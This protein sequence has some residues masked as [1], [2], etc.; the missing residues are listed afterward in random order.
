MRSKDQG[1]AKW[2]FECACV[3]LLLAM[4]TMGHASIIYDESISGDLPDNL[5][6]VLDLSLGTNT[7]LG[8]S[9]Y[10]AFDDSQTYDLDSFSFHLPNDTQ[11]T[12]VSYAFSNTI[13]EPTT[14]DL[15]TQYWLLDASSNVLDITVIA[16]SGTSPVSLFNSALPLASGQY[17]FY[18]F[19][20]GTVGT[21]TTIG[22]SWDY[23]ITFDVAATPLPATLPLFATGLGALGLLG[24]RRKRKN[25]PLAAA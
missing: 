21:A 23:Q 15:G 16:V 17:Q 14:S 2:F 8:S 13:L 5:T 10:I 24:W 25:A 20:L 19:S 6:T 11:L 7:V 22:G 4:P 3:L 12:N 18:N 1:T 9:V